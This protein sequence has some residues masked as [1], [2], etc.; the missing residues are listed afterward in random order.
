MHNPFAKPLAPKYWLLSSACWT[1]S[2]VGSWWLI[3][4]LLSANYLHSTA[5]DTALVST[6]WLAHILIWRRALAGGDAFLRAPETQGW[7]L[8]TMGS[9]WVALLFVFQIITLF[10][11]LAGTF[12]ILLF[13]CPT[14]ID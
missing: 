11:G 12:L 2:C 9:I 6:F 5:A 14:C 7:G 1:V 4:N 13:S 3:A 8:G 10:A